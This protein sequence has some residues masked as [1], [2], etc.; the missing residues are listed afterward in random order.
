MMC[1]GISIS[2]YDKSDHVNFS[3][4]EWPPSFIKT[5]VEKD[6][7]MSLDT[8]ICTYL[9]VWEIN[10]LPMEIPSLSSR[11]S[12]MISD[13]KRHAM[14]AKVQNTKFALT[15][16]CLLIC[17]TLLDNLLL[18]QSFYKLSDINAN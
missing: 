10:L 5:E 8:C 14:Q 4:N 1:Y 3:S 2:K 7:I 15:V 16:I 12:F 18:N 9:Y 17:S 13:S 11:P 6:E